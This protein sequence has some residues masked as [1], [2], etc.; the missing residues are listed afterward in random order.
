MTELTEQQI[1]AMNGPVAGPPRLV[2][3]H[4][5]ET[6]VLISL[7]EFERLRQDAY[8]DSPWTGEDRLALAWQAGA[9]AGWDDMDEYDAIPEPT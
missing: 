6:Y 9:R 2:N 5:N 3:P 1:Q 7:K 8:D 4:T